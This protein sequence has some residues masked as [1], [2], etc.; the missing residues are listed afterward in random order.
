MREIAAFFYAN[1]NNPRMGLGSGDER[2]TIAG[3][4]TLSSTRRWG[5]VVLAWRNG[6][7]T[8]LWAGLWAVGPH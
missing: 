8:G 4:M 2:E 1:S 5:D 7:W 3:A 6:L